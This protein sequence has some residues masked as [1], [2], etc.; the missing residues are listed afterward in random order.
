[1]IKFKAHFKNQTTNQ[2]YDHNFNADSFEQAYRFA[3][4]TQLELI[5]LGAAGWRVIGVY[6]ILYN[7][8]K[9]STVIH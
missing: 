7:V 9:L 4:E 8:E 5:E 2:V 1:M 3:Q 6:E